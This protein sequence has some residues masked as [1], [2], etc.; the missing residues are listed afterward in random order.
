M[1]FA[2]SFAGLFCAFA[3]HAASNVMTLEHADVAFVIDGIEQTHMQSS[4]PLHWDT[5][6]KDIS[7]RAEV[8]VAFER[9]RAG[10]LTH[11]YMFFMTRIGNAYRMELNETLLASAGELDVIGD[12][13]AAK[14]PVAIRFPA[15]L[16]REKNILRI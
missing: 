11:P 2:L 1:R 14:E 8:V 4:L 6:L 13:W 12:R 16:L 15:T 7:G 5:M 10:W 3:A 9:P